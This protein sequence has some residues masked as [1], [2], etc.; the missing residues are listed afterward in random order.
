MLCG[1]FL[2]QGQIAFALIVSTFCQFLVH[3]V[4]TLFHLRD[5]SKCLLGFFTNGG[6]VLKVHDLRQ[7]ADPAV[8]GDAHRSCCRLLLTTENLQHRRLACSVLADKGNTVSVV[9]DKTCIS[10][11]RLHAK[12]NFQSFYRNH[13]LFTNL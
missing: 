13:F 10:E 1:I 2:Y 6:I 8:I 11:Q 5:V 3:T 4:Q 9:D 12:L 7:I